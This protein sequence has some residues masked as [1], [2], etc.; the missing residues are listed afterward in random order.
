M[1]QGTGKH[2][3]AREGMTGLYIRKKTIAN[4]VKEMKDHREP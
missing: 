3:F 1:V 2:K 4:N